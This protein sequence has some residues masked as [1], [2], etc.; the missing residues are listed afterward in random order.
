MKKRLVNFYGLI[1]LFG[2]LSCKQTQDPPTPAAQ[3]PEM[4]I[5][6]DARERGDRIAEHY[7]S[8]VKNAQQAV[9]DLNQTTA[10][11]EA[12]WKQ[13]QEQAE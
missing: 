2:V 1:F 3:A 7:Q 5:T 6:R 8:D 13:L 11:H 4:A 10:E 12:M 9:E